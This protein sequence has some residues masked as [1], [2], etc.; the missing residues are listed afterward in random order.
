MRL[1]FKQMA[2]LMNP[3]ECWP[4]K[5]L[6]WG[7]WPYTYSNEAATPDTTPR[8]SLWKLPAGTISQLQKKRENQSQSWVALVALQCLCVSHPNSLYPPLGVCLTHHCIPQA[9]PRTQH[10]GGTS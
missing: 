10:T 3:D 7:G 8:M 1:A 9:V 2:D 6:P 4:S 5:T